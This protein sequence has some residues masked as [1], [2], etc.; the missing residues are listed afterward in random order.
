MKRLT[1]ILL[2]LAATAHA[3]DSPLVKAAKA[4]GGPRKKSTRKVITNADVR[5]SRGKVKEL[6]ATKAQ[7]ATPV[8]PKSALKQQDERRKA[9]DVAAKHVVAAQTKVTDLENELSRIEQRYY[10][11]NDPN[12]RDTTITSRFRQT[13]QQLDEAR[14]ELADARDAQQRATAIK[15][16]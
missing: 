15:S 5:K 1:M 9:A 7:A 4:G 8:A 6:P 16:Q 10:E 3:E 11:S 13:R 12:D 2:L 14:K